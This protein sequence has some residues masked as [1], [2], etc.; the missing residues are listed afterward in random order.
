MNTKLKI[1]SNKS[2]IFYIS[3]PGIMYVSI[4]SLT[5]L[6]AIIKIIK[7]YKNIDVLIFTAI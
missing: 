6:H 2:A 5:E 7:P 4:T 1:R 3:E